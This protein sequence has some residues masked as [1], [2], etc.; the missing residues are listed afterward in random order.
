MLFY[1]TA[2]GSSNIKHSTNDPSITENLPQGT[3]WVNDTT[4][5]LFI[6][7][8]NTPDNNVWTSCNFNI[9]IAPT[10]TT[11]IVDIF[12][13]GSGVALYQFDGNTNDTGGQYDGIA[14]NITYD[15]G[16]YGQGVVC[17]GDDSSVDTKYK[18]STDQNY[19]ISLWVKS[20]NDGHILLNGKNGKAYPTYELGTNFFRI[21]K[22][23]NTTN[24]DLLTLSF[25]SVA[26]NQFHNIVTIK[27]N[28]HVKIYVDGQLVAEGDMSENCDGSNYSLGTFDVD[29]NHDE[30]YGAVVDQLR[31]FNRALTDDEINQLYQEK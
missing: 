26:D 25:N 9:A 24:I 19:S 8:D 1:P 21:Y 15:T 31:I 6:C 27:D 22:Y 29:G 2:I 10:T 28:L 7:S 23:N 5:K 17:Q 30:P 14:T 13:D 20:Q 18:L 11:D 12:E 16:K 4:G 3:I